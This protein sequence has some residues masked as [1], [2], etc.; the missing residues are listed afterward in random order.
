MF[1]SIPSEWNIPAEYQADIIRYLSETK[2][3]DS[4]NN[5]SQ[6]ET[7]SEEKT[8]GLKIINKVDE[9]DYQHEVSRIGGHRI[10][11][12]GTWQFKVFFKGDNQGYWTDDR[13]CN[14]ENLIK[15]YIQRS[16]PSV[17]TMYCLCR[18]SS[19]KQS[20]P[21]HVSLDAQ[22]KQLTNF[23]KEQFGSHE[24]IRVKV[25]KISASAYKGIP[26]VLEMIGECSSKN[27][28]ILT[29]RVDRLSRNIVAILD[30]IEDLHSR[31]VKLYSWDEKMWYHSNKMS[32]IQ[33]IVNANMESD[34]ISKRVKMS[35]EHRKK[36]GDQVLGGLS[37]GYKTSRDKDGRV[38][39][40][41]NENEKKVI[42]MINNYRYKCNYTLSE[43]AALLNDKGL[44]K[45]GRYWTER[46]VVS[47]LKTKT[48]LYM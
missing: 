17:I 4:K 5:D 46:M 7:K 11:N 13:D 43:I 19:K 20:G 27:D 42:D 45:R 12:D 3:N 9:D 39:R 47:V 10:L 8:L 16:C 24:N 18:V 33:G 38:I 36:R 28:V 26:N 15:E 35:L 44:K 2:L 21:T 37:Y 14:C 31:G 40:V 22:E 6:V 41:A 25:Y 1:N 29:Y 32:F 48:K 30:F 34:L 23:V